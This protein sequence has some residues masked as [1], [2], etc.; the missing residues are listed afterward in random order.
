[1]LEPSVLLHLQ[2]LRAHLWAFESVNMFTGPGVIA[3][4]SNDFSETTKLCKCTLLAPIC[5]MI[6]PA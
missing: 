3:A 5:V 1:M 6:L 2:L 4:K